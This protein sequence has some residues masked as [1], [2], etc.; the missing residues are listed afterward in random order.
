[1]EQGTVQYF[2]DTYGFIRRDEGGPDIFVHWTDI[3]GMNGHKKLE[4]GQR[5]AYNVTISERNN[6]PKA[7]NV[8]VI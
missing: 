7:V 8:R 1:M 2:K 5:V 6:K 3:E 4:P